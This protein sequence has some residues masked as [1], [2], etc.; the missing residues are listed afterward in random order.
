MRWNITAE[1]AQEIYA[2]QKEV[3]DSIVRSLSGTKQIYDNW[4]KTIQNTSADSQ[5]PVDL[6]ILLIMMEVNQ[7]KAYYIEQL[8]IF[9]RFNHKMIHFCIRNCWQIR[10]KIKQEQFRSTI[11]DELVNDFLSI[12]KEH[13]TLFVSILDK[14]FRDKIASISAFATHGFK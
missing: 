11:L 3:F 2:N 1:N 10:K 13:L 6:I 12:L 5:K 4:L 9:R 8:V 14:L 7:D